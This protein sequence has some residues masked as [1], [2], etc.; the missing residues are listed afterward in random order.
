[1]GARPVVSAVRNEPCSA[2]PYRLDVASG[3]W[4]HDEYEKLRPYDAPTFEQ[5]FATFSCHATPSHHCAGWAQVHTSRGNEFDL[6][7]LRIWPPDNGIPESRIPLFDSGN[8]AAD[9]GQ[10]DVDD[11]SPQARKAIDRLRRKY[12]RLTD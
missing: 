2:C 6:I 1:M 11:P 12:P 7:A 5:P 10:A 8:D 4:H 9:H 3:V